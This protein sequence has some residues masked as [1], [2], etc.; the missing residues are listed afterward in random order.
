[1]FTV[2]YQHN[3]ASRENQKRSY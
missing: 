2:F 1:M 3:K